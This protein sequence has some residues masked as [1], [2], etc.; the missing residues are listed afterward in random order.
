MIAWYID[1]LDVRGGLAQA[2]F[3]NDDLCHAEGLEVAGGGGVPDSVLGSIAFF[4][5]P[6]FVPE[7]AATRGVGFALARQQAQAGVFLR[8]NELGFDSLAA[9][10]EFVRRVYL[11]G[12]GGDGADE[13]GGT[14]PPPSP[15]GGRRPTEARMT[16]LEGGGTTDPVNALFRFTGDYL[17]LAHN[18]KA[19]TSTPP[20]PPP[21]LPVAAGAGVDVRGRRLVRGAL[22]VLREIN[23]RRPNGN[24]T[25]DVLHWLTTLD[26]FAAIAMRMGL[27]PLFHDE[28]RDGKTMADW[29]YNPPPGKKRDEIDAIILHF[30]FDPRRMGRYYPDYP[31]Y[32][33]PFPSASLA[34]DLFDILA[35]FPVLPEVVP[36]AV[37]SGQN[38]QAL[39]AKVTAVPLEMFQTDDRE[40]QEE[41]AEL[42]LFA[43]SCLNLGT[44][45]CPDFWYLDQKI[46]RQFVDHLADLSLTWLSSSLPKFIYAFEVE[47]VI[48]GASKVL[49]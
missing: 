18:T 38:L 31:G 27:W 3:R 6:A 47:S 42:A 8:G 29:L 36:F 40:S 23:R 21:T 5:P 35:R 1:A 4:A 16:D 25:P 20:P 17:K 11:S 48:A 7:L 34:S 28:F 46:C 37:P 26:H 43:A 10:A 45:Q 44:D 15:E 32:P 9:V 2:T 22:R 49:A 13:N 30:P 24:V 39:L 12:G 33:F 19:G 14:A 41:R